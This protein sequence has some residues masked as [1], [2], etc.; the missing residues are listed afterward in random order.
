M[1]KRPMLVV[2]V[3]LIIIVIIISAVAFNMLAG[4]S[5]KGSITNTAVSRNTTIINTITVPAQNTAS[6]I[7]LVGGGST[8]IN[9]QMSLWARV[10]GNITSGRILVNYQSIGSAAGQRGVLDGSLDF[11][12]S[13]IPMT[14][15]NYRM[16]QSKGLRIIQ[17]PIIAGSVAVVYNLP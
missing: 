1:D 13:D 2:T 8:L 5:S 6:S 7:L 15:D 17:F 16:A 10:Y 9:P 11:G 3:V 12:G 14:P 4:T